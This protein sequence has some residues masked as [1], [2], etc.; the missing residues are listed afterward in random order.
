MTVTASLNNYVTNTTNI[1]AVVATTSSSTKSS[2]GN[3]IYI[4]GSLIISALAIL[5]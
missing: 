5:Y 1:T 2:N 4:C 3:L